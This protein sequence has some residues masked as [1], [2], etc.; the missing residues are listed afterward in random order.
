MQIS[1]RNQNHI[2]KWSRWF[3]IHK[4]GVKI[5]LH[6]SFKASYHSFSRHLK[7]I[8]ITVSATQIVKALPFL[9]LKTS[10]ADPERF[11]ADPDPTFHVDAD[12]DPT[13]HVDADPDPDPDLDF[14]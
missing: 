4:N 6:C 13:F 9:T 5:S 14:T 7:I 3:R 11:Y 10:V 1:P 8:I 12:P 2:Q